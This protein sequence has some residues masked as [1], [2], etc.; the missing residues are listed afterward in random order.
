MGFTPVLYPQNHSIRPQIP[1]CSVRTRRASEDQRNC[2]AGHRSDVGAGRT[3]GC[4]PEEQP[5][6]RRIGGIPRCRARERDRCASHAQRSPRRAH[7]FSRRVAVGAAV[8]AVMPLPAP[9]RAPDRAPQATRASSSAWSDA[10]GPVA[11]YS[12]YVQREHGAFK[13]EIDVSASS[14]TLRGDPGSTARVT[15]VAF[16]SRRAFGPSSPSSPLFTFPNP[17]HSAAAMSAQSAALGRR[18]R[19]ERPA[20]RN[21]RGR[22]NPAG[23]AGESERAARADAPGYARVAGR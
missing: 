17:G 1:I 11:G 6:G 12:V 20:D 2:D 10:N 22:R 9:D 5:V 23:P 7:Y 16:D 4:A 15:V 21:R 8:V 19:R 13:H 18:R 3:C 14:V